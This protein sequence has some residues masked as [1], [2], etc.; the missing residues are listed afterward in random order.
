MIK[1]LNKLYYIKLEI[2]ELEEEINSLNN[3]TS[4]ILTGMPHGT[5]ETKNG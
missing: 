5:T 1:K 3:I 2:K 4:S